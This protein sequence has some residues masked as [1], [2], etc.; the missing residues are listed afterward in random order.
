[1]ARPKKEYIQKINS[2]QWNFTGRVNDKDEQLGLCEYCGAELRYQY[3]MVNE[4]NNTIW[5]GSE[6]MKKMGWIPT[7][8]QKK[9]ISS[10]KK[11]IKIK[12]DIRKKEIETGLKIG[13]IIEGLKIKNKPLTIDKSNK[14]LAELIKVNAEKLE[15]QTY[16]DGKMKNK[17]TFYYTGNCI[18]IS[19]DEL[20]KYGHK[21]YINDGMSSVDTIKENLENGKWKL[22]EA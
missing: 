9:Q 1:M 5:V 13:S 6:C 19:L 16:I 8:S 7:D 15:E 12:E 2:H 18:I 14:K 20:N 3:E 17:I 11:E 21:W 22:L 10:I 4:L